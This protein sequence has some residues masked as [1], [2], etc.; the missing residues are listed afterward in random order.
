MDV[1]L[2]DILDMCLRVSKHTFIY[3]QYNNLLKM[4]LHGICF[5]IS[6][7]KCVNILI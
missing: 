6:K 3:F 7:K 2:S 1:V 5:I 4:G